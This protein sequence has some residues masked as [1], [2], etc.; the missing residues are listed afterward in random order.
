LQWLIRCTAAAG[1]RPLVE[2]QFPQCLLHERLAVVL[3]VDDERRLQ[4]GLLRARS[5]DPHAD[6][7]EGG[8]QRRPDSRGQE[9]ILDPPPHLLGRLVGERDRDDVPRIDALDGEQV[10]DAVGDDPG[11][12]APR[13]REHEHR[14]FRGR[15]RLALRRVQG[16]QEAARGHRRLLHGI[17]R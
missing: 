8:D 17:K 16:R 5:Q 13:P 1:E 9:E 12:A 4:T 11:L 2:I 15:D 3:V 6:R 7:V 14:P 10:G